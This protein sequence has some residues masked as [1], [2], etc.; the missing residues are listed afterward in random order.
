[1]VFCKSDRVRRP[2][3]SSLYKKLLLLILALNCFAKKKK[4]IYPST[5]YII[6]N[7][8]GEGN[9]IYNNRKEKPFLKHDS[10]TS[11]C[12]ARSICS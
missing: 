6:I 11:E 12:A 4:N 2:L 8:K 1:M 7:A 5:M 9:I 3:E 10:R